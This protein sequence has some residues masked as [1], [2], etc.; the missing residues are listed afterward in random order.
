MF[1]LAFL[2]SDLNSL[3]FLFCLTL[4]STWNIF[5]AFFCFRSVQFLFFDRREK[6]LF[7]Y[8]LFS[9]SRSRL[10]R[11]CVELD[12]YRGQIL[13]FFNKISMILIANGVD[14]NFAWIFFSALI[15]VIQLLLY[16]VVWISSISKFT[17]NIHKLKKKFNSKVSVHM[18]DWT[19]FI[20]SICQFL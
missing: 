7:F 6:N 8:I 17:L 12:W 18:F 15:S 9:F 11:W 2:F 3:P 10:D 13:F 20:G 5:D 14:H 1:K 19:N 16:A 4:F